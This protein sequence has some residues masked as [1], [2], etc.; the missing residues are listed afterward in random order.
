MGTF[1]VYGVKGAFFID[2]VPSPDKRT[3][4]LVSILA[5]LTPQVWNYLLQSLSVLPRPQFLKTLPKLTPII[6]HF[7]DENAIT[8]I[9]EAMQEV[10]HQW[11]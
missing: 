2:T 8:D 1:V 11:Q 3:I 4:L 9:V 7:A 10:C 5:Q 6:Q